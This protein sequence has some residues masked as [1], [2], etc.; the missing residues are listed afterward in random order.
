ML[1]HLEFRAAARGF[2]AAILLGTLSFAGCSSRPAPVHTGLQPLTEPERDYL[3]GVARRALEQY[4]RDGTELKVADLPPALRRFNKKVVF[5]T[6][7]L[8]GDTRGCYSAGEADVASNVVASTLRT[9]HDDRYYVKGLRGPKGKESTL[10]PEEVGQVRIEL[11]IL[12]NYERLGFTDPDSLRGEVE[13]GVHGVR[14]A[15]GKNG[16]YYLPYVAI[17][18][19]Y[20]IAP[21]LRT[22]AQKAGLK[23][24]DWQKGATLW[25]F[26]SENFIEATGGG[27]ALPLFRWN[28]L[29]SEVDA[30]GLG[31][32]SERAGTFAK[33]IA[34][35]AT[36]YAAWHPKK[37][38]PTGPAQGWLL[39]RA[40][41]LW[42]DLLSRR[43][44]PAPGLAE[45]TAEAS[46]AA[47]ASTDPRP[48]APNDKSP[49]R[50]INAITTKTLTL[51]STPKTP[52]PPTSS[53]SPSAVPDARATHAA[54]TCLAHLRQSPPALQP[55]RRACDEVV[56]LQEAGRFPSTVR[57]PGSSWEREQ[58]EAVAAVRALC[59]FAQLAASPTHLTFARTI[60]DRALGD[61][62]E[63]VGALGELV[64]AAMALHAADPA[65]GFLARARTLGERLLALQLPA[66]RVPTTDQQGTLNLDRVP[67]SADTARAAHAFAL[68]AAA[69]EAKFRTPA[70]DAAR[71]TLNLQYRPE[72]AFPFPQ[73]PRYLGGV[74]T[75]LHHVAADLESTLEAAEAWR[76][77]NTLLGASPA[78]PSGR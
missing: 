77:V 42:P 3:V 67:T 15:K 57:A 72:S 45:G 1:T 17:E 68:L 65:G 21:Y 11:N 37:K 32:A 24:D 64:V 36:P 63:R 47:S 55:A 33:A 16:A 4:Y 30:R 48:V 56:S 44:A 7:H 14:L 53:K 58:Q 75:D 59:A 49:V 38:Q 20:D 74:R 66:D 5:A 12:H 23:P 39:A 70:L 2:A 71:F 73:L 76:A 34:Q 31:L 52:F 62:G 22:L 6:F 50:P 19:E 54:Y 61:Y 51:P 35:D 78:P 40:A 29:V 25:R 43:S 27:K 28:V 69:G 13:P 46:G 9:V 41:S 8:D 26:E 60:F 10:R 18:F